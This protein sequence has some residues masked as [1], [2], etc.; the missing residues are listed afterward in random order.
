MFIFSYMTPGKRLVFFTVLQDELNHRKETEQRK[1]GNLKVSGSELGWR[2]YK[3]FDAI[4]QQ[5]LLQKP[6]SLP[7]SQATGFD[8][9]QGSIEQVDGRH[10]PSVVFSD[11]QPLIRKIQD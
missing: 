4:Y 11:Q 5:L 8:S 3:D 1:Q 9:S 7:S 10:G 6:T 2:Q